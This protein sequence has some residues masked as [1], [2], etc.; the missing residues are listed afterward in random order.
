MKRIGI[1]SYGSLIQDLNNFSV[2]QASS[3]RVRTEMEGQTHS[4]FFGDARSA[5]QPLKVIRSSAN[6]SLASECDR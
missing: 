2:K 4:V 5:P 1:E 3:Y 6:R